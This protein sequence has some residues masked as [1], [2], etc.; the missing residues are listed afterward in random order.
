[1]HTCIHACI[2]VLPIA[3][4]F[5]AARKREGQWLGEY[6]NSKPV[7]AFMKFLFDMSLGILPKVCI[8]TRAPA[9]RMH[10]CM[11]ISL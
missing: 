10:M 6:T 1:M 3:K 5:D 7:G 8:Y 4:G 9:P 2:Q 11:P